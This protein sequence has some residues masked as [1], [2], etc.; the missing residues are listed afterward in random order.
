MEICSP[1]KGWWVSIVEFS[2]PTPN[3]N[4]KKEDKISDLDRDLLSPKRL[5]G[6]HCLLG[7]VLCGQNQIVWIDKRRTYLTSWSWV[8]CIC[9]GDPWVPWY[10]IF[11]H[12]WVEMWRETSWERGICW[13]EVRAA[14]PTLPGPQHPPWPLNKTSKPNHLLELKENLKPHLAGKKPTFVLTLRKLDCFQT[15]GFVAAFSEMSTTTAGTSTNTWTLNWTSMKLY[16]T[17]R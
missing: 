1:Q 13:G 12:L 14:R 17:Q 10:V 3:D 16:M 6:Q 2:P 15:W 8:C 11:Y 4:N 7:G 9:W 5:V